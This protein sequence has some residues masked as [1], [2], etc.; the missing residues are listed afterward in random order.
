MKQFMLVTVIAL[1]LAAPAFL[2][3][4]TAEEWDDRGDEYYAKQ[5]WDNAINAFSEVIRLKPSNYIPYWSRGDTYTRKGDYDR[6]IADF[7]KAL[8]LK[9]NEASLY[10]DRGLAYYFKGDYD[11]AIG[12]FTESLR[13]V[14]NNSNTYSLRGSMYYEKSDY[15]QAIADHSK[16][17]ELNNKV[18]N[19]NPENGI[20]Y[21]NRGFNYG[22]KGLYS[23]AFSDFGQGLRIMGPEG[24]ATVTIDK[25]KP[26]DMWFAARLYA[27]I[28]INRFLG[29]SAGATRYEG[30]LNALCTRNGVTRA[31]IESYYRNGIGGLIAETV[32]EGFN[33][34]SFLM[35]SP[36]GGYNVVLT[37][38]ARTGQYALSYEDAKHVTKEISA[39][40]LE[41][42]SSV[43]SGK[44]AEFSQS[45]INELR[46][47]AALIPAVRLG[48]SVL[49]DIAGIVTSFYTNPTA[50]TYGAVRDVH[51][52]YGRARVS[53]GNNNALYTNIDSAY[54]SSISALNNA[55]G[56]K[57]INDV[58]SNPAVLSPASNTP[59]QNIGKSVSR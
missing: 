45:G 41:A 33:K 34:V 10:N 50:G 20:P 13:L 2:P 51:A 16:A 22:A 58:R 31:E 30:W 12:D 23:R 40:S 26:E 56:T 43:M 27:E 49:G 3:A 37:R 46:A 7:N 54:I 36:T 48:S 4:Q 6:A 52:I 42:L 19:P 47:Q 1:F 24:P 55:L 14:P 17:I 9:S 53:S 25:A 5:D 28:Q 39:A 32:G 29:D 57:M 35:G 44:P 18:K 11:Q 8:A 38:N 21:L 59:L 15:D